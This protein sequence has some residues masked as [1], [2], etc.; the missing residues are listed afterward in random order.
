[1]P[2]ESATISISMSSLYYQSRAVAGQ[3]L[4][5]PLL[6]Y[7]YENSVV[8]ALSDSSV[9][10]AEQV[11]ASLHCILTLFLAL[12]IEIP[13]ESVSFGAVTE[14]G[15][16]SIN[17]ELGASEVDEYY[18][19][20]RGYIE[21]QKREQ[22]SRVN[23]LLGDG[24]LLDADLLR[25]HVVILVADGLKSGSILEAVRAYLKPIRIE[26]L[27]IATPLASVAAVDTAHIIGDEL[28]IIN[29]IDNFMDVNHYY[30]ENVIPAHEDIIAKLNQMIL[31]WR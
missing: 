13:G 20:F 18:G 3:Q 2:A 17:S 11:A 21:E 30:T 25:D 7:R 1:M 9:P 19:E 10:V 29:V 8:V 27:I 22:T 14:G 24:G 4:I 6:K 28:H 26:K 5:P 31:S 16:F 23:R 15:S 12:D